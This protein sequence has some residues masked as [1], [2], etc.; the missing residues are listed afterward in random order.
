MTVLVVGAARNA[1]HVDLVAVVF[2]GAFKLEAELEL[3]LAPDF[4]ERVGRRVNG[5]AGVR[6]IGTGAERVKRRQDDRRRLV[7]QILPLRQQVR[8]VDAVVGT[9]E[10]RSR[11][12][13]GDVDVVDAEREAR[14]VE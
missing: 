13:H 10:T 4:R 6:R 1:G 8:I 3:V 7:R 14:F 2:A 12:D 5:A 9:V 11:G